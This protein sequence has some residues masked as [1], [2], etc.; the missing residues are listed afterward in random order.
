MNPEAE[1]FKPEDDEIKERPINEYQIS[2]ESFHSGICELVCDVTIPAQ[3]QKF[4]EVWNE[5]LPGYVLTPEIVKLQQTAVKDPNGLVTVV[6][7]NL[8]V[9]D[10]TCATIQI[11]EGFDVPCP[12]YH[13][14]IL[15]SNS[16]PFDLKLKAKTPVASFGPG[17]VQPENR[18]TT[19]KLAKVSVAPELLAEFETSDDNDDGA[20]QVFRQTSAVPRSN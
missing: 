19:M 17:F 6:S 18:D 10:P 11:E 3:S 8:M 14:K 7:P 15:V 16:G 4:V 13:R 12:K 5:Y 9:A 1:A 20:E 2:S